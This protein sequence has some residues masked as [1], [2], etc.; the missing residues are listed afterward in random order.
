MP[1]LTRVL[2]IAALAPALVLAQPNPQRAKDAGPD[3]VR[4]QQLATLEFPW[5]IAALP[6]GR[7]LITEKPGRLR[8]FA[9]GKLSAPLKN[10]PTV[11]YRAGQS[12]QG[13]MLD[14]AV[15]PDFAQNR[16]IYLSYTE[17]AKQASP[18]PETGDAR[19]AKY[20]DLK[21]NRLRG[22]VVA[23]A[24]LDGEGLSDVQVIWKQEPK[25][26]GR[27]HFGHRLVFGR[28]GTLF[29][30]SGER[31]R[32][33]PAQELSSNLGKIVRINRDGSIPKDN[34]FVGKGN[35]RGDV[36]SV[37]HRNILAAAVHPTSGNL[38]AF[39]MG[40][41]GGDELNIIRPGRNYG[42]PLVSNGVNYDKSAIP[43]HSTRPE[44]EAP[45]RTWTPVI[46]PSGALF[47][48]GAM[49]PWKGQV[50]V[51][52]LSSQAVIR[53][54]LDGEKLA[55]EERI[56]M[57]KRIRDVLQAADGALLVITDDKNGELLRLTPSS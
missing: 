19:F 41:F 35:A 38:W 51:G 16:R 55:G 56:E 3:S 45:L 34:P 43:E 29:I 7:L 50:I 33:D 30:T 42:W 9:D 6:D 49:F 37:G 21:D 10:V 54:V 53:L 28:D 23:R 39:E 5:G 52:G 48:D 15:D 12:E 36:W 24:T 26:I 22:G 27:G 4:T 32:F 8:I 14:V 40:P 11:S 57:K 17:E 20:L 1:V 2:A 18:Q 46:S 13:G 25:A 31:M 44:F 47:Y